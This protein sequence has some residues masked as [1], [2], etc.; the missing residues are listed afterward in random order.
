MYAVI[1]DELKIFITFHNMNKDSLTWVTQTEGWNS[2]CLA[3]LHWDSNNKK[4]KWQ[5]N[6][7]C[8]LGN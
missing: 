5:L 6:T 7:E 1:Y 2:Y 3:W 4:L 8:M